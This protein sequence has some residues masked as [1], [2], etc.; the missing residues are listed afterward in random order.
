MENEH[1]II[2]KGWC[3]TGNLTDCMNRLLFILAEIKLE[4]EA[5]KLKINKNNFTISKNKLQL[6]YIRGLHSIKLYLV[7]NG[8]QIA[9]KNFEGNIEKIHLLELHGEEI[10][11]KKTIREYLYRYLLE[12]EIIDSEFENT[13]DKSEMTNNER[14]G[15]LGAL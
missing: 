2:K 7:E 6:C 3:Y 10:G 8:L 12:K 13:T 5:K 4:T 9:A 1:N 14:I 15:E 11:A